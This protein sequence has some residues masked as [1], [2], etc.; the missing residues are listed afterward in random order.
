MQVMKADFMLKLVFTR[1]LGNHS[2]AYL[3]PCHKHRRDGVSAG[4]L[5]IYDFNCMYWCHW[6]KI[7][8]RYLDSVLYVCIHDILYTW[9]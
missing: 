8:Y 7:T 4:L 1:L 9:S 2:E 5:F 6:T 3:F